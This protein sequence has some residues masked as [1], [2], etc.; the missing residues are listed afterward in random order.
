[1]KINYYTT[2]F[3]TIKDKSYKITSID[4][5]KACDKI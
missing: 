5:E 4:A 3:H 1:M 2:T